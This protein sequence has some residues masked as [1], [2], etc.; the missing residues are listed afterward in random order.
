MPLVIAGLHRESVARHH[1]C[2]I[3]GPLSGT[4]RGGYTPKWRYTVGCSYTLGGRSTLVGRLEMSSPY[5][6]L[7][8]IL[9]RLR[10]YIITG[11]VCH[12]KS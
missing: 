11:H 5:S 3:F 12:S 6:L 9:V 7:T 8:Y 2:V 10:V 4:L 1:F